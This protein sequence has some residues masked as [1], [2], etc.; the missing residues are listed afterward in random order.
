MKK[1]VQIGIIWLADSSQPPEPPTIEWWDQGLT[2]DSSYD[3]I[4]SG[5][6]KINTDD[7]II[8]L[9]IQHPIQLDPPQDKH[10]PPPK[11]LP[12]TKTEQRK[13][14]R[15][16]R[17]AAL[18]EKQAKIQL[19]LEPPPPPKIKKSNMMRVLGEEAV[20]DPTAVEQRVNKE[21]RER[22]EQHIQGNEERKLTKEQRL[23]KLIANQEK[24]I[25]K[26]VHCLVFRVESLANGRHRFKI[27]KTAEQLSLTGICIFN[28]KFNLIVVEG[29]PYSITKFKKLMINRIDW[30]EN[31][32]PL[33]GAEDE[34]PDQPTTGSAVDPANNKCALVWEGEVKQRGFRKFTTERCPTD[35]MAKEKLE[36]G[37]M[38]NMWT[39]AKDSAPKES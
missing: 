24:D 39:L 25:A 31:V 28:P 33:E 20:R 38:E 21:I 26:G 19:G 9:Y 34:A 10:I 23:E 8:T 27:N 2:T 7:S 22:L 29:G 30:T 17:A 16:R 5:N 35:A 1:K 14:R 11:S 3:D 18:K 13:V 4:E 15:Q 6:L 12:L 36:R 32:V 37:R